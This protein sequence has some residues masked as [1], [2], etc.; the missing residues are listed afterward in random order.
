M[1]DQKVEYPYDGILFGHKEEGSPDSCY[2]V[3]KTWKQCAKWKKPVTE[4]HM[5]YDSIYMKF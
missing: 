4:G 2:N 3:E 1:D 5:S